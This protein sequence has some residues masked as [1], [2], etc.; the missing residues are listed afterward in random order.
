MTTETPITK[1]VALIQQHIVWLQ[2]QAAAKP[3]LSNES[4]DLKT[5]ARVLELGLRRILES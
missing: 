2:M 1:L 5:E 4:T 3:V